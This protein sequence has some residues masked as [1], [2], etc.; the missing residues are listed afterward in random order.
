MRLIG[1]AVTTDRFSARAARG[2]VKTP[3]WR[4][5][6]VRHGSQGYDHQRTRYER[7]E[8][9]GDLLHDGDGALAYQRDRHRVGAHAVARDAAGGVGAEEGGAQ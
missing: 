6:A 5:V 2:A 7:E 9:A 8:L 1:F 3:Y 4:R